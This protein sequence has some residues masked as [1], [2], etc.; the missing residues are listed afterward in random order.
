[1]N[2]LETPGMS[3]RTQLLSR[4]ASAVAPDP[5][6]GLSEPLLMKNEVSDEKDVEGEEQHDP[7]SS[8][9]IIAGAVVLGAAG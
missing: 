7:W 1:M 9:G 2:G 8:V 5:F 3:Y 4:A 6:G